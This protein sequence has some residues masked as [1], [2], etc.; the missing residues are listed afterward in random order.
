M[1][2]GLLRHSHPKELEVYSAGTKPA[3]RVHP[4]AVRAMAEAGIDIGGQYP[5][6]V[7]R[8]L[9]QPFDFVITVCGNADETC[10]AFTGSVRRRIHIPFADPAAV[11]VSPE[12]VLDIFREVRDQI[13]RRLERLYRSEIAASSTQ[14]RS[15]SG[16]D[17]PEVERVLR[18]CRLPLDGLAEQF[19]PNYVV[20]EGSDGLVGVAG[21]EVHGRYG[22]LRSVAIAPAQRGNGLAARLTRN[23]A[24]WARNNHLRA[25]YLLTTTAADY[26]PA[27]GFRT[28][29]R[30]EAPEEIRASREF[31]EACPKSAVFMQLPL[32]VDS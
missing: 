6:S 4:A 17:L 1:A 27:L 3:E 13:A 11:S 10:P 20:A 28:A 16:A 7:D 5:K 25:L 19:G 29:A 18:E 23:R 2:E 9:G 24:A 26:F 21:V 22:L 14:L 12:E 30:E 32:D 31:A 8:Y 15:A